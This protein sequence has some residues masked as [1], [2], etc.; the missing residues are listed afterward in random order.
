MKYIDEEQLNIAEEHD[1]TGGKWFCW[2]AQDSGKDDRPRVLNNTKNLQQDPNYYNELINV[3]QQQQQPRKKNEYQ[4]QQPPSPYYPHPHDLEQGQQHYSHYAPHQYL[5]HSYYN[6]PT[7]LLVPPLD[8]HHRNKKHAADPSR[9]ISTSKTTRSGGSDTITSSTTPAPE[10]NAWSQSYPAPSRPHYEHPGH[11]EQLWHHAAPN[12]GS[13]D[14]YARYRT[15]PLVL[16]QH[17]S[18]PPSGSYYYPPEEYQAPP[19]SSY[20][21]RHPQWPEGAPTTPIYS[22]TPSQEEQAQEQ[23]AVLVSATTTTSDDVSYY[24]HGPA[25]FDQYS[26]EWRQQQSRRVSITAGYISGYTSESPINYY[27]DEMM[28]GQRKKRHYNS[29]EQVKPKKK[30]K[31]IADNQ[32]RRPLSAY[33]FFF[34]EEK[35]IVV[36][37]LPERTSAKSTNNDSLAPVDISEDSTTDCSTTTTISDCQ[38]MNEEESSLQICD[39]DVDKIQEYLVESKGKLPTENFSI[40]RQ[41]VERQTERTLLAHLEG[42]KPKKSH[43]KSHGKISFQKLASVIGKRWHDLSD[44]QKKRYFDLAKEDQTRFKKQTEECKQQN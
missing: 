40:L 41:T 31:K 36:A 34:S 5:Q 13:V 43:K 14:A 3:Q 2:E 32:P 30:R 8:Q 25:E 39:M 7:S 4:Q 15:P 18:A 42:D 44:A 29:I 12:D 16:H 38:A 37:L 21:H 1:R 19:A 10:V 26:N 28:E 9:P 23:H 22:Y 35:D 17:Q 11:Q 27:E 6:Y 20:H 33:N 24:Q